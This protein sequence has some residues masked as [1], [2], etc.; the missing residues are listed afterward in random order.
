V[1]IIL[2]KF[3]QNAPDFNQE[4]NGGLTLFFWLCYNLSRPEE[5]PDANDNLK[6]QA[7]ASQQGQ[8]GEDDPHVGNLPPGV[9]L[10]PRTS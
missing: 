10:V 1:L 6:N 8:I 4:M 2:R 5:M 3:R 7:P 9:F